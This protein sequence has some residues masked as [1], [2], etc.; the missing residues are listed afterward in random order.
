M[1]TPNW[2]IIPFNII[3][4]LTRMPMCPPTD[5]DLENLPYVIIT[6]DD[7]WDPTI[8]NHSIDLSNDTYDHAMDPHMNEEE[9]SSLDDHT[10][11]TGNYL[12]H[13]DYG[14][15]YVYDVYHND[16]V[17]RSGL[18]CNTPDNSYHLSPQCILKDQDDEALH[19]YLLWLPIECIKHTLTTMTQWF[20]NAYCILFHKQ[21]KSHFPAANVSHHNEPVAT[22][23]MFSDE[24]V[25]GSSA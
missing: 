23:T 15:D 9:F 12:H 5:D 2:W 16:C 25:L 24:P 6:T 22:N 11:M 1:V 18:D 14:P 3:N 20:C 17:T 19:P 13:D 4:G 10:C 7:I 21:F 8:L